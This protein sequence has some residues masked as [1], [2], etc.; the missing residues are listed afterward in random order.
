MATIEDFMKLDIRIGTI[1]EAEL[2]PEARKP[3]I[4]LKVDFGEEVGMKQSSAQ[5]TKRYEPEELIGRQ[6]IGVVNFPPRRIAGFKSEV[7]IIGGVPEEGDVVLLKP[8][9][10]VPNG[11]PIA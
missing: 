8:D 1:V 3:A 7:L 10:L 9:E 5:I 2:F 11:T 4:K 6:V